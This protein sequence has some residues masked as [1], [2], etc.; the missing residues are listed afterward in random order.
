MENPILHLSIKTIQTP[1]VLLSRWTGSTK[2]ASAGT[3]ITPIKKQKDRTQTLP[4]N[5]VRL[6]VAKNQ[7][8]ALS[9][10]IGIRIIT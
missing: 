6:L 9:P 1:E 7:Q 3:L 4:K 2:M 5:L 8:G 10:L